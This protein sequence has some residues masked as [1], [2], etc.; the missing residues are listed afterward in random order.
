MAEFTH[1]VFLRD[2]SS[3][4]S[5]VKN[6]TST[7]RLASAVHCAHLEGKSR[8]L[9][10]EFALRSIESTHFL[11]YYPHPRRST[12]NEVSRSP[13]GVTTSCSLVESMLER[14]SRVQLATTVRTGMHLR[15]S[16][17]TC[18]FMLAPPRWR[19]L[20]ELPSALRSTGRL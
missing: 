2:H 15:A 19:G 10:A 12:Y 17:P 9:P 6:C 13:P 14:D 3:L 11:F 20:A 4:T 18:A 5:L 16:M 7:H 1:S 8:L